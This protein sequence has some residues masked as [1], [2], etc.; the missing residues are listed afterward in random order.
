ML[1]KLKELGIE[2]DTLVIFTSDNGPHNES[3]HDLKRFNPSGPLTG[4]KRSLTD[5]GIRVPMLAWWPGRI[6]SAQ[7]SEHVAY[8]GDFFATAAEAAGLAVPAGLDSVSFLPALTGAGT[9]A[10]HDFLY[11]EFH[12]SGFKQAALLDGRWKA[13]RAGGPDRPV[14]L[15]DLKT[16]I[17]ELKDVAAEH[18]DIARRLEE[19]LRT[20]RTDS[21]EWKPA[22]QLGAGKKSAPKQK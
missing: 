9:Q 4:I 18:P 7:E 15:Y 21:A 10:K 1:A 3:R 22:W 17:G 16:D 13:I 20:A 12:E 2:K 11:W 14:R 6:R 19:Y 8:A 5:G